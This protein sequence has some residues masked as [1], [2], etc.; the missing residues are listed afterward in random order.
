MEPAAHRG[1]G[2][3]LRIPVTAGTHGEDLTRDRNVRLSSLCAPFAFATM[4]G[5]PVYSGFSRGRLD[6]EVV[7][8]LALLTS[9][10]AHKPVLFSEFGN[11]TCPPGKFSP[12]ERVALP[13]EPPNP[14]I[15]PEDPVF[16]AYA[17]VSED[18]MPAYCTKA[19]ERLH[20]DGRLG[21]YWWCWADYADALRDEPPFDRA[22]TSSARHRPQRR[23]RE[24]CRRGAGGLRAAAAHGPDPARHA[25]DRGGL[26]LSYAASEHPDA[27]RRFHR[28]V[29][30]RRAGAR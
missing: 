20:A 5:Y 27:V 23:Q 3:E 29:E 22:P 8:F 26:L 13:D 9:A 10:F 18:E 4:H 15:L 19:L 16:A 30:E 14:T 21:A 11:P 28:F 7:P 1:A 25:A 6:P 2:R 24:T 17:C 12:F